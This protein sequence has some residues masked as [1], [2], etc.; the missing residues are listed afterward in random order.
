MKH[1]VFHF[2]GYYEIRGRYLC[3]DRC[4]S[5]LVNLIMETEYQRRL[6]LI[7]PEIKWNRKKLLK[8]YM[9]TITIGQQRILPFPL[10]ISKHFPNFGDIFILDW[11]MVIF[12]ETKF[13]FINQ[14]KTLSLTFLNDEALLS[15]LVSC[16]VL[17]HEPFIDLLFE[18]SQAIL[19]FPRCFT[20]SITS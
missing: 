17:I 5:R 9:I 18:V 3:P 7:Q 6:G 15:Q 14:I 12:K 19:V 4:G 8:I 16:N 10:Q 2:K 11:P 1:Q 20:S 13:R